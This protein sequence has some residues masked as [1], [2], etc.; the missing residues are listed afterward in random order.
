VLIPKSTGGIPH[1]EI[2]LA[3]KLR[4]AGYATACI[5]K[6]HLGS[7]PEHSPLAHGF[8]YFFGIPYSNDMSPETQPDNPLFKDDPPTPLFR[9]SQV[10]NKDREP[11]QRLLTKWYTEEAI[12]FMQ[13]HAGKRPFFL[14]VAHTMPHVPLYANDGF[15]GRSRRGLYGDTV[16]ELDWSAGEMQRAIKQLGIEKDTLT[17]FMSDNGPWLGKKQDGG[18]SGPFFEGK[19]STFEGGFRVPAIFHWP[20]KI[21]RGSSSTAFATAMDVFTTA[22]LLA[23]EQPPMDRAIDGQDLSPVLLENSPG[24]E[25]EMYYYFG[26]ELWSVR[27]GAWKIHTKTTKPASVEKWGNWPIETHEP[28]LLY[29]VEVDPAE[30]FNV[31]AQNTEIVKQ[32]QQALAM[33]NSEMKPGEPQR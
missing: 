7:K 21:P 17:V 5:G 14:Y 18:S 8:D 12:R 32:L 15:R 28:P 31:A 20:G 2:T 1:E 33:W 26:E 3:E 30:R 22:V 16:E 29:N 13:Q 10:T 6:W 27:K 24:R 4:D 9:N 11:D 19:V 23:G 25:P